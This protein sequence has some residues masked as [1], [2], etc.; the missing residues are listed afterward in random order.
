M[1]IQAGSVESRYCFFF[2]LC[3]HESRENEILQAAVIKKTRTR[4]K[5]SVCSVLT[6]CISI[7][8]R[9]MRFAQNSSVR[10]RTEMSAPFQGWPPCS[11][12]LHKHTPGMLYATCVEKKKRH[13]IQT[14]ALPIS[15]PSRLPLQS[16]VGCCYLRPRLRAYSEGL[17]GE[18]NL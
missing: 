15:L 1:I 11:Q 9:I 8:S 10:R 14:G 17:L 18:V 13:S 4:G 12:M 16:L 3:V 6:S 7:L 2:L 5:V